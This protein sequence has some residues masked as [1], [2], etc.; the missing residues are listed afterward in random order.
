MSTLTAEQ[1]TTILAAAPDMR[2]MQCVRELYRRRPVAMDLECPHNVG[3]E[4]KAMR[5]ADNHEFVVSLPAWV[6]R[7]VAEYVE[8]RGR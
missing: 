5:F 6:F 3:G 1:A 2:L 8:A 4:I 7:R